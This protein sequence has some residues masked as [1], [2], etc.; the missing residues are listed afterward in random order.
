LKNKKLY[1]TLDQL[2]DGNAEKRTAF[3]I[4]HIFEKYKNRDNLEQLFF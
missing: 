2:Q 4:D 1:S 3:I